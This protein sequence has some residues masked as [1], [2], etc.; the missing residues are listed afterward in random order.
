MKVPVLVGLSTALTALISLIPS[1]QHARRRPR[2]KTLILGLS[3]SLLVISFAAAGPRQESDEEAKQSAAP[4]IPPQW[5]ADREF[6]LGFWGTFLFTSTPSRDDR[7]L[8]ADHAWGGGIDA[9][10]FFA[11]YFGLGVEGYVVD[12]TRTRIE[13]DGVI[14]LSVPPFFSGVKSRTKDSRAVGSV[15]GTF[16]FRYPIA[17]SRI[18]PY[19]FLRVGG[20]FGGGDRDIVYSPGPSPNPNDGPLIATRHTASKSEFVGQLGVGFEIRLTPCIGITNDFSWN[21]LNGPNNNFGMVRSGINF[22][23]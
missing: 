9:K 20:I 1:S 17:R 21:A 15:L 16:T 3:G 10:Y 6:D 13:R 22:A 2:V 18:A 12:A 19:A 11:R 7:Y 8:E 23:F 4:A 14:A 5:Y